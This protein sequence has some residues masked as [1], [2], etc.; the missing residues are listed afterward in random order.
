MVEGR[1]RS[2]PAGLTVK[3]ALRRLALPAMAGD[4]LAVDHSVLRKGVYPPRV[5]INGQPASATRRLGRGDRVTVARGH[6]RIE[7]V[8]RVTQQL[9]ASQP[10]HPIRSLPTGPAQA[11]L[12]RGQ[13][14]GRMVP[15]AFHPA[16][17][18]AGP[19]PVAL[20]FDDGPWPHTTAQILAIHTQRQAPATFFTVGRQVERYPEVLVAQPL[21]AADG[22]EAA[23]NL[24]ASVTFYD[25]DERRG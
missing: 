21:P 20:T 19:L 7:P 23:R 11:I 10:D 9:A 16:A 22:C 17:G 1:S 18:T 8:A 13:L 2:L 12:D 15:V 5:L 24:D 25:G 14:S 3:Q 4:L 6:S